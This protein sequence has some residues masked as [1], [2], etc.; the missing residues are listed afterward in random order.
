MARQVRGYR[1]QMVMGFEED[2][3]KIGATPKGFL[4]PFNTENVAV[5]RNKNTAATLRGTRNPAEPFDGNTDVSGDIVVPVD[6][7]SLGIWLRALFGAPV[8]DETA[9]GSGIYTH[10]FES[11]EDLPSIW[12]QTSFAAATPF[13]KVGRGLKLSSFRLDAG[14]DGELVASLSLMGS[15][16]EMQATPVVANP[17][18]LGLVR[19]S[20]FLGDLT[21][22]GV[23]FGDAT[24]FS[25]NLDN[26]LDGDTYTIGGGGFRGDLPEGLM[27]MSG[28]MTVLLKDKALY[29]KALS[30]TPMSMGLTFTRAAN[31]ALGFEIPHVQLQV[32]GPVVDGPAGLRMTWNWQAY[33]TTATESAITATL[34]NTLENYEV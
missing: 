25:I 12:T 1:S 26:G 8:S 20:N 13:Y 19:L 11:G 4:V 3:A 32:S 2:Y 27:G 10:I 34:T 18:D 15:N 28:S 24:A 21:L 6:A 23:E 7:N 17:V 29:E 14:G 5:S 31:A 9:T 30:S 16:Q 22:D 33:S